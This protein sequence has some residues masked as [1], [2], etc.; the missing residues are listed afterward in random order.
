LGPPGRQLLQQSSGIIA[1]NLVIGF[2]PGM[3]ISSAGHIGGLVL[4]TLTALLIFRMPRRRAAVV[5]GP[6]DYARPME[7]EAD[8]NV[9]TIEHPPLGE[10]PQGRPQ[11]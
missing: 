9:V 4:G 7:D 2:I 11:P 10:G 8:P 1:I 6:A 5:V 3:N